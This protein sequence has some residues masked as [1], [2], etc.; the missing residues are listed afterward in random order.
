MNS[1]LKKLQNNKGFD[2]AIIGTVIILLLFVSTSIIIDTIVG[3][4]AK[5]YMQSNINNLSV[6]ALVS[7]LDEPELGIG[8]LRGNPPEAIQK[9]KTLFPTTYSYGSGSF[10]QYVDPNPLLESNY[11]T[12]SE[13]FNDNVSRQTYYLK[14]TVRYTPKRIVKNPVPFFPSARVSPSGNVQVRVK[15]RLFIPY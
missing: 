14:A 8:N 1:F 5:V 12:T 4:L 6:Y 2:E 10:Y 7:T 9:F 11:E 3:A 15:A 13:D